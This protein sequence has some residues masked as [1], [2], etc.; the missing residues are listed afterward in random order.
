MNSVRKS[1]ASARSRKASTTS[2]PGVA[3]QLDHALAR[4][5]LQLGLHHT[6]DPKGDDV[7]VEERGAADVLAELGAEARV[8]EDAAPLRRLGLEDAAPRR[9]APEHEAVRDREGRGQRRARPLRMQPQSLPPRRFDLLEDPAMLLGA[10]GIVA[11]GDHGDR[12]LGGPR[13]LHV[14]VDLGHAVGPASADRELDDAASGRSHRG[15]QVLELAVA[16][17]AAR[18]RA[19]RGRPRGSGWSSTRSRWRRRPSRAAPPP[20][21]ARARRGWPRAST[22]RRP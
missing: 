5:A 17:E 10:H 11:H 2:L 18:H 12:P 9:V 19:A 7:A 22:P 14:A 21:G 6:L 13:Q 15:G 20:P 8:G 16:A 1:S 4:E 3:R